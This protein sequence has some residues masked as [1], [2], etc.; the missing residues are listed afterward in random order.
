MSVL[1]GTGALGYATV[2]AGTLTANTGSA[3]ATVTVSG[4]ILPGDL[5]VA[6]GYIAGDATIVR[7]G[8]DGWSFL[9]QVYN[10]TGGFGLFLAACI[11]NWTGARTMSGIAL[12]S[13]MG[14]TLQNYA[15]RPTKPFAWDIA[16]AI[17]D[18]NPYTATA[19]GTGAAV[20]A[21]AGAGSAVYQ[22]QGIELQARGYNNA[23]TTTTAGTVTNYSERFDTGQV[24]PPYGITLD[25][26]SVVTQA[27][28]TVYTAQSKT[29]AVT[30]TNRA[31]L[32]A[33]VPLR[34]GGYQFVNR[35]RMGV[36]Y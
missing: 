2:G 19:T 4:S 17:R 13:S 24:S 10:S 12:P 18:A 33:F 31:G 26:R 22:L 21:M 28:A 7:D 1:H 6:V 14:W 11:A 36:R 5:V 34:G 32:R 8:G 15:Y 3:T 16:G 23:G 27:T 29:L 25:D 30:K 9:G 35:M 20:N